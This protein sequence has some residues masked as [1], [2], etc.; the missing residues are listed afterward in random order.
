[1]ETEG[2]LIVA[3]S[4]KE[5]AA[6]LETVH[7]IGEAIFRLNADPTLELRP[8]WFASG[9][10][11][12]EG[13]PARASAQL[14]D[15]VASGS[16]TCSCNH[17]LKLIPVLAHGRAL[18]PNR[19]IE[20]RLLAAMEDSVC[21]GEVMLSVKR[22]AGSSHA[23]KAAWLAWGAAAGFLTVMP[24][25][26]FPQPRGL[27]LVSLLG[28]VADAVS[29]EAEPTC[30]SAV[31]ISYLRQ[32][33]FVG[34][35]ARLVV[36]AGGKPVRGN[37]QRTFLAQSLPWDQLGSAL[38][39]AP[40]TH[41]AEH[42][43]NPGLSASQPASTHALKPDK[44]AVLFPDQP[45]VVRSQ[46]RLDAVS[47][48]STTASPIAR[49]IARLCARLGARLSGCEACMRLDLPGSAELSEAGAPPQGQQQTG[50]L[51][52]CRQVIVDACA[53]IGGNA[54]AFCSEGLAVVA[55]E[56]DSGR[57]CA[58][59]HN[60]EL[61]LALPAAPCLL[62]PDVGMAALVGAIGSLRPGHLATWQG[63][64][65]SQALLGALGAGLES[66]AVVFLDPPWPEDY[67]QHDSLSEKQ[68]HISGR[69]LGEVCATLC[70]CSWCAAVVLKLPRCFDVTSLGEVLAHQSERAGGAWRVH[71]RPPLMWSR[72]RMLLLIVEVQRR[73]E[74]K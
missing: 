60:A 54:I 14:T 10:V 63:D 74:S 53:G 11:F 3:K 18:R 62:D 7:A 37:A 2:V 69:A 28:N 48:Y 29:N 4:G 68:V 50:A 52:H 8:L 31:C 59:R 27:V 36:H 45:A 20:S 72:V 46:L 70:A 57:H 56:L 65:F 25:P 30:N 49:R 34:A 33:A 17:V 71:I 51:R 66:P 61:L 73:D 40:P 67:D 55:A 15:F 6:Y 1:M 38:L 12:A 21:S 5:K 24:A 42:A 41:S 32:G 64:A 47:R 22:Y 39:K 23:E 9:L 13:M 35:A 44:L 26:E 43:H 19:S 58:L 16:I